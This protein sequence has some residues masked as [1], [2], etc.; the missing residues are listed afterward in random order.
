MYS[1]HF[2]ILKILKKLPITNKT[3]LQDTKILDIVTKWSERSTEEIEQALDTSIAENTDTAE[4]TEDDGDTLLTPPVSS[5]KN[6]VSI[7][8]SLRDKKAVK[9]SVKFAEVES[10]SD[11]ESRASESENASE[12]VESDVTSSSQTD[13]KKKKG[14]TL[15]QR[16]LAKDGPLIKLSEDPDDINDSDE[17]TQSA[18]A[19]SSTGNQSKSRE[20]E[21]PS[22]DSGDSN[23]SVKDDSAEEHHTE[24]VEDPASSKEKVETS[25]GITEKES[26]ELE[27]I[28]KAAEIKNMALELLMHWSGLKVTTDTV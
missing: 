26:E 20:I 11:S 24:H 6:P 5:N 23:T 10:S 2:Q 17:V 13:K 12:S 3:I 9:K 16:V 21:P 14:M 8:A 22:E 18:D 27:M 7:L 1:L 28:V 15:R 25:T 4:N 19:D